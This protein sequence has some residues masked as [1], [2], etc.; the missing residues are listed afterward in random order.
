M[1]FKVW[2]CAADDGICVQDS[3]NEFISDKRII[4]IKYQP[5]YCDCNRTI[6]D[7]VLV[8]YAEQNQETKGVKK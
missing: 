1:A 4:D 7:R 2:I 3:V 5:V 6:N 8:V